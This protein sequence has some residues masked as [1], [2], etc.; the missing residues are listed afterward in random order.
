MSLMAQSGSCFSIE[1]DLLKPPNA[2]A[3][4]PSVTPRNHI[5]VAPKMYQP[6]LSQV[7]SLSHFDDD[8]TER[9]EEK[10]MLASSTSTLGHY[11]RG[12]SLQKAHQSPKRQ[13]SGVGLA[14]SLSPASSAGGIST[15]TSFA[16]AAAAAPQAHSQSPLT[17]VPYMLADVMLNRTVYAGPPCF[18]ADT[19]LKEVRLHSTEVQHTKSA[20]DMPALV[21]KSL[22]SLESINLI[23]LDMDPQ[24]GLSPAVL[25]G[26]LRKMGYCGFAILL[27]DVSTAPD[28]SDRFLKCGG[29]GILCKPMVNRRAIHRVLIGEWR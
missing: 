28:S 22:S 2:S 15:P 27:A 18:D 20:A 9:Y 7:R 24:G 1:M 21:A 26:K 17:V 13:L 11:A 25:V 3:S 19:V 12:R 4:T 16:S 14:G 10:E 8:D 5:H 23:I 29:D 6:L